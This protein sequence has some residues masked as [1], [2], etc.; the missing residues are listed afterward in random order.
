MAP[1][2]TRILDPADYT[3]AW[4]APLHIEA[5]AALLAL[6]AHHEGHFAA[7]PGDDYL[8]MAGEVNCHNVV[9]ATFPAEHDY[10]LGS[11][12]ALASQVKKTP[13]LDIRLGDVLVGVGDGGSAGLVNYS[14]GKQTKNGLELIRP[15]YQ[16]RTATIVRTAIARLKLKELQLANQKRPNDFLQYYERIMNES[17]GIFAD[18]GQGMDKLH[19][20]VYDGVDS[21]IEL[22]ERTERPQ[23]SRTRLWYGSIGSGN[24]LMKDAKKR[25]ELRDKHNL[26]GFE[27]EA[28]G[29]ENTI[30]VGVIRG[31]CDYGD[32]Q[33]NK[34][35][36]PYAAAMAAAYAKAILYEITPDRRGNGLDGKVN[37][38][39][40]I[41]GG[42]ETYKRQRKDIPDNDAEADVKLSRL[43]PKGEEQEEK[44]VLDDQVRFFLARSLNIRSWN[45]LIV[46]SM[47]I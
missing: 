35:W 37:D 24:I 18:P 44:V 43:Y 45:G 30:P 9:I 11:A 5:Q 46:F 17:D 13:P 22:V 47:L 28:S 16:A 25:D 38:P 14:L 8:Y 39:W 26:I 2:T 32:D 19:R 12:A 15:G 40:K 31:V 29:I 33:K 20:T 1:N 3:V 21:K 41:P 34:T 4:I 7:H 27:M 42:S 10:G 6:D 36:H 23:S